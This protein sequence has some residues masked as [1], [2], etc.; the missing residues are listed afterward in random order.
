MADYVT[1][2]GNVLTDEEIELR[3]EQYEKGNYGQW[4][5]A[6]IGRPKISDEDSKS[7]SFKL[8]VSRIAAI[9]TAATKCGQSRSEFIRSAL[10][11]AVVSQL[12]HN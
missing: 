2:A 3:S 1:V 10:D 11:K 6:I 7:I 5:K 8:P 12:L 9:D 4:G